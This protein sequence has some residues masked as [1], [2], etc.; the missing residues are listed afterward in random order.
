M[1]NEIKQM[2]VDLF[3]M[4]ESD[5]DKTDHLLEDWGINDEERQVFNEEFRA[6]F[7]CSVVPPN[8][9]TVADYVSLARKSRRKKTSV[10]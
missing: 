1:F 3:G 2:M 4:R 10:H 8:L 6:V 5:I 7:G 9:E